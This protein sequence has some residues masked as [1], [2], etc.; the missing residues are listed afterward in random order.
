MG[1][2]VDQAGGDAAEHRLAFLLADVLLQLDEAIGHRV[3]R[4]AEL[5]DF[6]LAADRDALVQLPSAIARVTRVS[7]KMRWMNDRPHSQPRM[8]V[9]SSARPMAAKSCR[10]SDAG[11]R[12]RVGRLAARPGR[13]SADC[14]CRGDGQQFLAAH[15]VERFGVGLTACSSRAPLARSRFPAGP[16]RRRCAISALSFGFPCA[17][18]F[19]CS[20]SSSA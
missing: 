19:A 13:S 14:R 15:V 1:E 11:Q 17:S 20:S 2:V 16:R 9:P 18:S 8:T 4:V 5:A 6:V 10:C 7:A 3:E 12:E